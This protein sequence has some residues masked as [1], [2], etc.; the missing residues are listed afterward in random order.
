MS[1]QLQLEGAF[2]ALAVEG[3]LRSKQQSF[4]LKPTIGRSDPSRSTCL[5][6]CVCRRQKGFD[7]QSPARHADNREVSIRQTILRT[8][9]D[10][11]FA[12][13]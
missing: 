4:E 2:D 7:R 3:E 6:S 11:G 12:V 8:R 13:E 5:F 9:H 1:F 10:N